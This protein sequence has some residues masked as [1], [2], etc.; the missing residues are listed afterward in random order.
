MIKKELI[1]INPAVRTIEAPL[2]AAL[3]AYPIIRMGT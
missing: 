3:F 2:D 1:L